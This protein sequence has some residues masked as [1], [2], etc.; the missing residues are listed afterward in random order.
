MEYQAQDLLRFLYVDS[1]PLRVSSRIVNQEGQGGFKISEMG[2]MRAQNQDS[3][4]SATVALRG[5]LTL[6]RPAD[7]L[8]T[9]VQQ[10]LDSGITIIRLDMTQVPFADAEGLGVIAE[11]NSQTSMAGATLQIEGAHGKLREELGI[12]GLMVRE[13]GDSDAE[14]EPRD[15]QRSRARGQRSARTLRVVHSGAA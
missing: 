3:S 8:R 15:R 11:C 10:L 5:P 1:E 12:T 7:L 4:Q 9:T 6:G 2:A 14:P 13:T